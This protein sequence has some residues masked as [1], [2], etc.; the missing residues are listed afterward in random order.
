M[1][2]SFIR[3]V[4]LCSSLVVHAVTAM[5]VITLSNA[6]GTTTPTEGSTFTQGNVGSPE[7]LSVSEQSSVS[8][9]SSAVSLALRSDTPPPSPSTVIGSHSSS[10]GSDESLV[11]RL[12]LVKI[13]YQGV[14]SRSINPPPDGQESELSSV[15]DLLKK[16]V[17]RVF[18]RHNVQVEGHWPDYPLLVAD[19]YDITSLKIEIT[20]RTEIEGTTLDPCEVTIDIIGWTVAAAYFG[21]GKWIFVGV[22]G[23]IANQG[24]AVYFSKRPD[25]T[26]GQ[27]EVVQGHN[28]H[29]LPS[30]QWPFRVM[31]TG[32]VTVGFGQ[33]QHG[34]QGVHG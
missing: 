22:A 30:E 23:I 25:T 7:N 11:E 13:K 24:D 5:P 6:D 32:Y 19:T 26:Y 21:N 10:W 28:R 29:T 20:E 14:T 1:H 27:V 34:G 9:Q 33:P 3:L 17:K 4:F 18:F 12:I 8:K 2:L 31:K 15:R 16:V